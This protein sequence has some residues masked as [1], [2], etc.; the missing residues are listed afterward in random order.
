MSR[1]YLDN[2]ATTFPKAPGVAEAVYKYL[3]TVGS[4]INRGHYAEAIIAEEVVMKPE[5]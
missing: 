3:T 4:N 5:N 1:I 2:A